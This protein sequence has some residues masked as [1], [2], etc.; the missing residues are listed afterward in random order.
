MSQNAARHG[1]QAK[2]G[3][4][5]ATDPRARQPERRQA[6]RPPRARQSVGRPGGGAGVGPDEPDEG[7]FELI[8]DDDLGDADLGPAAPGTTDPDARS[9]RVRKIT[10]GLT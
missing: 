9:E 6:T 2:S 5:D 8:G 7:E 1:Q 4:E 3:D 10:T